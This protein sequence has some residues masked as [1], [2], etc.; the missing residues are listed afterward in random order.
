MNDGLATQHIIVIDPPIYRMDRPSNKRMRLSIACNACRQ[1]KVKCDTLYPKCRRCQARNEDCR[2]TN[3]KHPHVEIERILLEL[4]GPAPS[5]GSATSA[6]RERGSGLST[7]SDHTGPPPDQVPGS[8]DVDKW[9]DALDVSF[10]TD[11]PTQK[12]KMLGVSSVQCLVKSVDVYLSSDGHGS[13]M[14]I[15]KYGM[16]HAE[17]LHLDAS[18]SFIPLP[19]HASSAQAWDAFVQHIHPMFPL[20]DLR[21]LREVQRRFQQ[22]SNL[23]NTSQQELPLLMSVY[24]LTSVG[25]DDA[26]NNFSPDGTKYLQ[27]AAH[28]LG[29]VMLMPYLSTVQCLLLFAVIC[30]GRN[31]GGVAWQILGTAIRVGHSLGLHRSDG[32]NLSTCIWRV[33]TALE[34]MMQLECGRPS[35][36]CEEREHARNDLHTSLDSADKAWLALANI[37]SLISD[38]IYKR[39]S[40]TWSTSEFLHRLG[41]LDAR[42]LSFDASLPTQLRFTDAHSAS[43]S[44]AAHIATQY[45]IACLALHRAALVAPTLFFRT[46]VDKHY[47]TGLYKDRVR[48]GE[49]ICS[50]SAQEIARIA[51]E[52][53][54]QDAYTTP[55]S[56]DAP[57]LACTAL[58]VLVLK[59]S[60]KLLRATRYEVRTCMHPCVNNN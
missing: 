39:N 55:L 25:L 50:H 23:S 26:T 17:E 24:L 18:C 9:L 37:Q 10:N 15:F 7:M 34:M 47:S 4:P 46:A 31:K 12:I 22:S 56:A 44:L 57:M 48:R 8:N 35:L 36:L 11:Q 32:E 5:P 28:L 1:R 13:V 21:D 14:D 54:E 52:L 42:L 59:G 51:L 60:S 27:A 45:H 16:P 41:R 58:A 3:T 29:P 49:S 43:S 30:R 19:S 38:L 53:T 2:T 20:Y 40:K 33:A 6:G